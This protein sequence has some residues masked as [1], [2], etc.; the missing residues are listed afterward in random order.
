MYIGIDLGTSGVK[1]ILTAENGDILASTHQPLKVVTPKPL[2]SEQDPAHWW[3]ATQR[4]LDQLHQQQELSNVIAIGLSG[5]MHGATL[6][7][8]QNKVLRPAILWNDGRSSEQCG[9]LTQ[10]VPEAKAITGNLIMPGFTAPKVLWVKQNEPE[11]FSQ[12]HK[13]LLPK[14]YLRWCLT[15]DYASDM[16][17]SAGTSWLDVEKRCWSD[18]M[19][20]ATGLSPKHMPKLYEGHEITGYLLPELAK[21]W[22][23]SRVAVVAGA[24]DNAAGAIGVGIIHSG[25]AMLSLGTSG[26][27]F[28]VSNG[29]KSNPESAVHSFCHALPQS[30]HLMSV[31][32]SAASCLQWHA[33]NTGLASVADLI[34]EVETQTQTND[35]NIPYF[36]P[37]LTGE[38]TPYNNPNASASFTG[39]TAQ[40]TRAHMSQAVIQGV[41]MALADGIDALH[42]AG[43]EPSSISLIGGGAKSAYWRQLLADVI[44]KPIY[45]RQGGDV[46]PALGAARLAQLAMNPTKAIADICPEPPLVKQY[47]PDPLLREYY[48]L[49]R[50]KFRSLYQQLFN[51]N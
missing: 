9:Q 39:I 15:G 25:Q 22:S 7:D 23:M 8:K 16:S 35:V 45:Y 19:L 2:W 51:S 37:Y 38:R 28:A 40:T 46:G 10:T 33:N 21:R 32:L 50:L 36:L 30:W 3:Q 49:R 1:A 4:C 12:I 48:R 43:L 17:D 27:Y 44:G 14:D 5:Q 41:S 6:I 29:Y 20:E 34:T 26:V 24:G 11:I 47:H 13:V 31:T 18:S 42:D